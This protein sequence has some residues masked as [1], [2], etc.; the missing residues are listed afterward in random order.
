VGIELSDE[1]QQDVFPAGAWLVGGK[2]ASD[3]RPS[4]FSREA[5]RDYIASQLASVASSGS[6][7]DLSAGTLP[8]GRLHPYLRDI[9][10]IQTP[11][12]HDVIY[13]DGSN[14]VSGPLAI[15]LGGLAA[16]NN[17]SDVQDA[18]QARDNLGIEI[19]ADVQAYAANLDEWA[20]VNP[21]EN[22]KSLVAAANYA[23][24]RGLLNIED[25][26]DVTDATNVAAAGAV[27]ASGIGSVV[28]AYSSTLSSLAGASANGVSLVTAANYAAMRTLLD[29]EAGTDFYS[30][31]AAN[32]A[33]QPIDATLTALAGVSTAADKVIYATGSD[34][35]STADF[36]AAG[37][38]IVGAANAG[39][40][41]AL[42]S[43]FVG[44]TGSGGTK[45]LVP[46]PTAG[47]AAANKYLK[48][49]GTWAAPAGAGDMLGANN[50]S[51]VDDI[52]LA[53]RNLGVFDPTITDWNSATSTGWY[54][55][56]DATNGPGAGWW[57][58]SVEAQH[59]DWVT[60]TLHQFSTASSSDTK[61]WRRIRQSGSWGAWF[62]CYMS[63]GELDYYYKG[64]R[65][66]S[67]ATEWSSFP[68]GHILQFGNSLV[69]TDGSG[70]ASV[71]YPVAFPTKG[72]PVVCNGDASVSSRVDIYSQTTSGF[73]I[74]TSIISNNFR[75]MWVA[76]GY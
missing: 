52:A 31:A 41:T 68:N 74:Q 10:Q 47:D 27:M 1:V 21:S 61:L 48:S 42:L 62:L 50:L 20:A 57:I 15:P 24:I 40:Q 67:G 6:A 33:F 36:T 54:T 34:T 64:N 2:H 76:N 23:A 16:I 65:S 70:R 29:L 73:T 58:G 63:K 37:R 32:A 7:S 13:F 66:G 60:Q 26:A 44:D 11:H 56:E 71:S 35:F 49:D 59:P 75:V 39:A 51:D 28:Q 3:V 19:G 46:A 72:V 4:A 43:A 53:R 38:S 25:G 30:I 8:L 14:Y 5:I 69:T 22:G 9:S 45:G 12:Q 55:A 17:L 18:S